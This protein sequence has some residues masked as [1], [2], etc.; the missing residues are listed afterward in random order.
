M[1]PFRA[2][3]RSTLVPAACPFHPIPAS[4]AFFV[5]ISP[6]FAE[7]RVHPK[8]TNGTRIHLLINETGEFFSLIEEKDAFRAFLFPSPPLPPP[9]FLLILERTPNNI[10]KYRCEREIGKQ[11]RFDVRELCPT[12]ELD[13]FEKTKTRERKTSPPPPPPPLPGK[14]KQVRTAFVTLRNAHQYVTY[15]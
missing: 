14:N 13:K 7:F 10:R 2:R 6:W 8:D 4:L 15:V 12:C 3:H 11:I 1:Q 5:P 9:L